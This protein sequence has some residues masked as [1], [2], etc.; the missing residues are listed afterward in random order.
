MRRKAVRFLL[1]CGLCLLAAL[2]MMHPQSAHGQ[3]GNDPDGKRADVMFVLDVTGTMRFAIDGIEKGLEKSLKILEKDEIEAQVGL[4]VFRDRK[5]GNKGKPTPNDKDAGITDDPFTFKF[6]GNPFT[7]KKGEFKKVVSKLKAEGGGDIPENSIEA[8]KH[9]AEAKTRTKVSR[10]MV[11]IT[12]APPHPGKDI[13]KRL[14]GTRNALLTH[15]YHHLYLICAPADRPLYEKI[16][17]KGEKGKN[18][19]GV[20]FEISNTEAAFVG[21]LDKIGDQT[22]KDVK[23]WRTTK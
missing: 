17:Q 6:K 16:W 18:V 1:G 5:M 2:V 13:D 7:D 22:A 15:N 14:E 11:L 4:T 21:I 8:L 23:R 20:F 12:D 9:A 3:A 19:N 10:I